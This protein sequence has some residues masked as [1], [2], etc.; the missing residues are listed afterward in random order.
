MFNSLVC[1][2]DVAPITLIYFDMEN[3]NMVAILNYSKLIATHL[4]FSQLPLPNTSG[5]RVVAEDS[6]R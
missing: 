2:G 3:Y 5:F 1:S 6:E 4:Q